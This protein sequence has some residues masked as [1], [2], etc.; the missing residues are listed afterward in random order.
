[1]N[2]ENNDKIIRCPFCGGEDTPSSLVKKYEG[3]W[4][5]NWCRN[6]AQDFQFDEVQPETQAI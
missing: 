2:F 1:M 5:C 3:G 4:I 6:V